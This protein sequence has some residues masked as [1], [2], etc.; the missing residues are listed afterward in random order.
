MSGQSQK[1][2][3]KFSYADYI[4][5]NDENRC[6]LIDGNVFNMTAPTRAHQKILLDLGTIMNLF[7]KGKSCEVYVA[8]FDVRL[9]KESKENDK[10]FDVVQP[11]ISVI[12]DPEKLDNHGCIGA[13]DLVV[14]I[15]SSST[16]SYDQIKKRALY[17]KHHVQEFWIIHPWDRILTIYRH[18]G[19]NYNQYRIFA[20][21]DE[22]CGCIFP[23]LKFVL[24]D[25]LP[26]VDSNIV[27][28]EAAYYHSL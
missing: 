5:W 19:Q 10:I 8:P 27:A 11:D 28:D 26:S 23:E 12:C 14:E 4:T 1:K 20:E 22:V 13:P 9:T 24:K 25:I 17:E 6:E 3:K 2:Q 18:S 7:F 21:T 15:L 16:A